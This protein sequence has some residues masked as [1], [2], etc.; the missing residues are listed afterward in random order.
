MNSAVP[1]FEEF[2]IKSD[3]AKFPLDINTLGQQM[4]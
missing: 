3:Y 4:V 2:E 1:I